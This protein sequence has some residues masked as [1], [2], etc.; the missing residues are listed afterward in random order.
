MAL[1]TLN[2]STKWKMSGQHHTSGVLPTYYPS[3]RRMGVLVTS[4]MTTQQVTSFVI[5]CTI[6]VY[7]FISLITLLSVPQVS[8]LGAQTR[9]HRRTVHT[10]IHTNISEYYT[11]HISDTSH[12]FKQKMYH[13]MRNLRQVRKLHRS[14]PLHLCVVMMRYFTVVVETKSQLLTLQHHMLSHIITR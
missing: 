13:D 3:D 1:P 11:C 8:F 7:R 6:T 9:K 14:V 4:V 5:A 2:L 10:Y 12:L